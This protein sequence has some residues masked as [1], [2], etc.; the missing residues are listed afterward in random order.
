MRKEYDLTGG[1]RGKFFGKVA[2]NDPVIEDDE[3]LEVALENELLVLASNLGRI[4]TLRPRLAELDSS[5]RKKL[6]NRISKASEALEEIA[7]SE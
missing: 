1:K 4:K 7:L 5:T 2:T 6:V 3:S